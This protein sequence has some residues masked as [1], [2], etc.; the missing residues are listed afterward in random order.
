[1]AVYL[2][3]RQIHEELT[4]MDG[5]VAGNHALQPPERLLKVL[6]HEVFAELVG[7]DPRWNW[8]AALAEED[9]SPEKWRQALLDHAYLQLIAN[10]LQAHAPELEIAGEQVCLFW[11][12]V[13]N[14]CD[15]ITE[16][17][18]AAYQ[19]AH[20]LP[21]QELLEAYELPREVEL[22]ETMWKDAVRITEIADAVWRAPDKPMW[23]MVELSFNQDSATADYANRANLYYLVLRNAQT[24]RAL[25]GQVAVVTFG[26]A[27]QVQ[28]FEPAELETGHKQLK[29]KIGQLAGVAANPFK[30]MGSAPAGTQRDPSA[31]Y[32]RLGKDLID[33]L[34]EYGAA[35]ELSGPPVVGDKSLQFSLIPADGVQVTKI[36]QLAEIIKLRLRL[37]ETPIIDTAGGELLINIERPSS[38]IVFFWPG[39]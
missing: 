12:A 30:S 3:L 1:M 24:D 38:G 39:L 19:S 35:A 16:R 18:W 37:K 34:K 28:V 32:S 11:E 21:K 17:L 33:T 23:C 5:K 6:F 4:V 31:D 13:R 25:A 36:K 9:P 27:P 8:A 10:R 20:K 15:W 2:S 14:L 29:A 26:P 7:N 22:K